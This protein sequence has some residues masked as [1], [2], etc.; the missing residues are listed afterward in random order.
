MN[1]PSGPPGQGPISVTSSSLL[2]RVRLSDQDAWQAL[3]DLYGPVVY[4]WCRRWG[5]EPTDAMDVV[6]D[7]FTAVSSAIR[8]FRKDRPGDTFCGWLWTIARHEA[9]DHFARRARTPQAVGGT[10]L[11]ARLAE[12]PERYPE[13]GESLQSG[14]DSTHVAIRALEVIRSDFQEHTWQAFWRTTIQGQSVAEVAGAL[15][16]SKPAVRQAKHRVL[17]RLREQFSDFID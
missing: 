8:T 1:T 10:D 5:V 16:L 7:V 3:V 13:D 15:K 17:Q 4:G 9:C 12:I 6:Q 11:Q 2:E 14:T